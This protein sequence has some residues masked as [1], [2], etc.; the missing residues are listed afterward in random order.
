[1]RPGTRDKV[2]R[3][4][5]QLG[6]SPNLAAQA[7]RERHAERGLARGG[8]AGDDDNFWLHRGS[9]LSVRENSERL[10]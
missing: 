8:R 7:L 4:M 3:A 9:L 6:Y 1:M 5:E 10:C 2:L